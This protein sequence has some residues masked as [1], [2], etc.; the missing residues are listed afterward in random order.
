MNK[1]IEEAKKHPYL[2]GG[3]VL[4][5]VILLRSK[6]N[7]TSDSVAI[8]AI[9]AQKDV[10]I[11]KLDAATKQADSKNKLLGAKAVTTTD[12]MIGLNMTNNQR[13]VDTSKIKGD[14]TLGLARN[15]TA[16]FAVEQSGK[17]AM[18][19]IDVLKMQS[20][21]QRA[22]A[23]TELGYNYQVSLDNNITSQKLANIARDAQKDELYYHHM[24]VQTGADVTNQ[25]NQY[26]Y[27]A[28]LDK[29]A[30]SVTL[31]KKQNSAALAHDITG[32]ITNIVASGNQTA[33]SIVGSSNQA[34][35]SAIGSIT[36]ML[37]G[38]GSS[39]GSGGSGLAS[40]AGLIASFL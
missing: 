19:Q 9:N 18:G 29:D 20:T 8:A 5:F 35:S 28:Q 22:V 33:A 3:G 37:G 11:A 32:M 30:T 12:R 13:I 16:A 39:G 34:G 10:Q 38:S 40:Y 15:K 23:E 36:G 27:W 31:Q 25:A 6:S 21:N 24:D 7:G 2:L 26:A 1:Y 17:A 14:L 4:A